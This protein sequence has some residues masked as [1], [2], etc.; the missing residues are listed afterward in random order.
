[1]ST[2]SAF[3]I[4]KLLL[5][6]LLAAYMGL[7]CYAV[8]ASRIRVFPAPPPG[9]TDSPDIMKF[10]YDEEGNSVSMV[11]L[12]NPR[13]RYLVFYHHGN[14]EDLQGIMPRLQF[15]IDAG[16]SVLAWDY[17]GYG[18]SDGSPTEGIVLE[19]AG[20]IWDTIPQRFP[21]RHENVI[22]YGR[23]LG[24]GP[25]TWLA[26]RHNAA[27]L[28]LEGTFTSVFRVGLGTGNVRVLPWDI[29]NNLRWIRSIRCPVLVV[30]GTADEVVPFSHGQA[31][32]EA[33]PSPK[34]FTWIK[35]GGHSDLKYAYADVLHSS[36]VRFR[37]FISGQLED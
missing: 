5:L 7:M 37:A 15:L 14:A 13:S 17:P 24:G 22:L 4:A 28:V 12:A 35:D 34:S 2:V 18:T 20:K 21:Y 10:P 3:N 26:A 19:I 6:G 16:F 25:A 36:L 31:L 27:G 11:Y 32:Y 23:S 33:A 30:H 8:V 9:Y 29:F 1:M